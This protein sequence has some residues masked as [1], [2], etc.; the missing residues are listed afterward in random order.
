[1]S[2]FIAPRLTMSHRAS[3]GLSV[4]ISRLTP[5]HYAL[6]DHIL[7]HPTTSM[8]DIATAFGVTQAWLSTVYHSDLFQHVLNERRSAI[9]ADF[10]RTTIGKLRAIADKGLD[11]LTDALDDEETPLT[12]QQ[13]ITEMALKGLGILGNKAASPSVVINNTQTNAN[14]G[15]NTEMA[16]AIQAARA[17]IMARKQQPLVI[18]HQTTQ[19]NPDED[20]SHS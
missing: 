3:E 4:Q 1:M 11:N 2:R 6:M 20:H 16:E 7:S 10:D 18:E 9:T 5:R 8:A 15:P 17:R 19:G 12:M 14:I 13:S